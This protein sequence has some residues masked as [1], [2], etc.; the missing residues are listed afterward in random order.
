MTR[1]DQMELDRIHRLRGLDVL[2]TPP[3]KLFDALTQAARLMVAAPIAMLSLVD[4][5]RQWFKSRT[6][7]IALDETPRNVAF[8]AHA[9][10]ND[11]VFEVVDAAADPR[12]A[13]NPLVTRDGIRF[14]AGAPIILDDGLRMG[15]LCVMDHVPRTLTDVQRAILVELATAS[16]QAL[17][18]RAIA[19]RQQATLRE[20]EASEQQRA[21][22]HVRLGH[23]LDA[24]RAAAWEWDVRSGEIRCDQRWAA[25]IGY[26]LSELEPVS[27]TTWRELMHADD[28]AHATQYLAPTATEQSPF[29]VFDVR[30]R[31][32]QGHWCW[33]AW[34]GR[35]LEWDADGNPSRLIGASIDV[36]ARKEAEQ[37]LRESQAFLDRTGRVAGVGGWEIDVASGSLRLSEH[38]CRI[39][40]IP[41]GCQLSLKEGLSYY[42]DEARPLLE[43]AVRT[44]ISDAREWDLELPFVT[45]TGRRIWVRVSGAAE[46]ESGRARW[47]IGAMQDISVRKRAVLALEVS[48]RRF[49]NLFEHS[50]GL[51]STH[52]LDG[53]IL[54]VNKALAASL[55]YSVANIVGRRMTEFMPSE[56]H[57]RFDDYLLRI[58]Q[59]GAD[60]GMLQLIASD[61]SA[62]IWQYHNTLDLDGEIPY[63]LG[64]AQDITDR[65]RMQR[66]LIHLSTRDPLTGCHN[67]R[68][69]T[70]LATT[71][72]VDA[73]GCIVIDLDHFKRVND[74][75]G[76]QRG[77]EV[78]VAMAAFLNG[79]LRP[80]DVVVRAGGDEFL[81]LLRHADEAFTETI[82]ARLLAQRG[83]APIA[84]SL[85]CTV[86][87]S[88]ET[89]EDALARADASLYARR[90]QLR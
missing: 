70:D 83:K 27:V 56:Y 62:R 42:A 68:F 69:L 55:R 7:P 66:K 74:Q 73:W 60:S 88:D 24:T 54:S 20:L 45:A 12:F 71:D 75:F 25:L 81:V 72:N 52:D 50:L 23:M 10:G 82:G 2:D 21:L 65:E 84:F 33:I 57:V 41:I 44:C 22:E 87:R 79:Q 59:G 64:H 51:I 67:R 85:G 3:E 17:E 63:V 14:Y 8:C 15:T 5:E 9:I 4:S 58:A 76:H 13:D 11:D 6:G 61:G 86:R 35:V 46:M 77:D 18:Q 48:E 37:Q 89:L 1:I 16:A 90:A 39:H 78:L 53:T 34:R 38:A 32:K 80:D 40:E 31:H 29:H 49:R 30:L 43:A 19:I 47:V 36:T 26:S 28:R